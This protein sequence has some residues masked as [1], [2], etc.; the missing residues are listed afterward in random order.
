MVAAAATADVLFCSG[1]WIWY[2]KNT[3]K[4]L[5]TKMFDFHL[6]LYAYAWTE[7]KDFP[8]LYT[9]CQSVLCCTIYCTGD[10]RFYSPYN[11]RDSTIQS[12]GFA[13]DEPP[14]GSMNE[15]VDHSQNRAFC[16]RLLALCKLFRLLFQCSDST[17]AF[18]SY[19]VIMCNW[20]G[21]SSENLVVMQGTGG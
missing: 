1:F 3:V 15:P 16:C 11:F 12:G 19:C 8:F 5:A 17:A 2:L 4:K 9:R 14:R 21:V 7:S 18:T 6:L 13:V 20:H 10:L